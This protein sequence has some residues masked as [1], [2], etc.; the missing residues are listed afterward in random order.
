[1]GPSWIRSVHSAA[2][3]SA[4]QVCSE[5]RRSTPATEKQ[6]SLQRSEA[7]PSRSASGANLR[8]RGQS[9]PSCASIMTPISAISV[10]HLPQFPEL[11]PVH[12]ILGGDARPPRH[13]ESQVDVEE[14][15]GR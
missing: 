7:K 14:L 10:E 11:Q 1:M 3:A 9:S 12:E 15:V 8:Q 2:S 13:P 4:T 6:W 5:W